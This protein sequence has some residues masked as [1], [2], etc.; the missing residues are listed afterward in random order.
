MDI[1]KRKKQLEK[2]LGELDRRLHRIEDELDEP[3]NKDFGERA[4]ERESEE[5]LEDLGAAGLQETRMIQAA[6]ER[7]EDGSYGFCVKCG[8]EIDEDR[9]DVVPQAPLCFNCASKL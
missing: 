1:E 6:L 5:V 2:R 4:T 3:V 8:E 7:I 9:L